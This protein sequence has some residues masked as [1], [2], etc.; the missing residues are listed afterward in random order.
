MSW[1][2]LTSPALDAVE[3][4]NGDRV[5]GVAGNSVL[6]D[7]AEVGERLFEV[8]FERLAQAQ[9]GMDLGFSRRIRCQ[10]EQFL[11]ADLAAEEPDDT[12]RPL[13]RVT[14]SCGLRER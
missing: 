11:L 12:V 4:G 1:G 7:P 13:L 2:Q 8:A 9:E 14:V 5:L 10:C 3:F 6:L